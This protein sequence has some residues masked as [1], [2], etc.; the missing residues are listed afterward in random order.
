MLKP[1]QK[2]K[3]TE[4]AI[5]QTISEIFLKHSFLRLEKISIGKNDVGLEF[6]GWFALRINCFN[7]AI[8]IQ[9]KPW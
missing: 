5:I 4:D 2:V 1:G 6:Q 9:C 3:K 8:I 7:L